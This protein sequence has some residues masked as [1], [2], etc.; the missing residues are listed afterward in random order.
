MRGRALTGPFLLPSTQM[1]EED[2]FP[3][4]SPVPLSALRGGSHYLAWVQAQNALGTALS[5]PQHLDL[6]ELGTWGQARVAPLPQP[7]RHSQALPVPVLG[8]WVPAGLRALAP[9]AVVPALPLA[10]GAETTLGSP[11]ITTVRWRQQ[12]QLEDVH[13]EERHKAEDAPMW[14]VRWHQPPKSP[15]VAD[16]WD[17][18]RWG[19]PSATPPGAP[20]CLQQSAFPAALSLRFKQE[21][22][23]QN[24]PK[25]YLALQGQGGKKPQRVLSVRPLHQPPSPS[26]TQPYPGRLLRGPVWEPPLAT[27]RSQRFFSLFFSQF[28]CSKVL[29]GSQDKPIHH[30][31]RGHPAARSPAALTPWPWVQQP[32]VLGG[33]W[34]PCVLG[35][36][37]GSPSMQTGKALGPSPP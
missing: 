15:P 23:T 9:P 30:T 4:G 2:V 35:G 21:D 37:V 20:Q 22:K 18:A 3:A 1:A 27:T 25:C 16:P 6:Q 29:Q 10:E 11:P 5:A 7:S 12:T 32:R 24:I 36:A 33:L 13:C 26:Q 8:R 34:G 19:P 31:T 17:G 14:H 28:L